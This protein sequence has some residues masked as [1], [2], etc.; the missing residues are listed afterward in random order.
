V[1]AVGNQAKGAGYENTEVY[2]QTEILFMNIP[3]IHVIRESHRKL[4]DCCFPKI[5][6]GG[7]WYSKVEDS[8]WLEYI[9]LL[10]QTTNT[11][12]DLVDKQG[13]SVL[14]H[15]SDGWDRTPQLTSLAMLLLDPFYRTV[16]GFCILITKEWFAYGHKFA[17]RLGLGN[18]DFNDEQ[19]AP[20]FIQFLDCVFQYLNQFPTAFEFNQQLLVTIADE[21]YTCRF[22]NFLFNSE[23]EAEE[24]KVREKTQSLWS[25]VLSNVKDFT[26]PLYIKRDQVLVPIVNSRKL[27]VWKEYC[28][29]WNPELKKNDVAV[30]RQWELR[31]LVEDLQNKIADLEKKL[32]K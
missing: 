32:D 14:L 8:R 7:N 2:E 24:A 16:R 1:N 23:Q 19:R 12:V 29:R 21:A 18:K 3:N 20:I 13:S 25:F 6:E 17:Q 4:R 27:V 15:C 10:L 9:K 30:A 26:N 31:L 22:G 5:E 28:Y 11:I